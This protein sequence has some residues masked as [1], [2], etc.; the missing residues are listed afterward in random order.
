MTTIQ[1]GYRGDYLYTH[2]TLELLSGDVS[3]SKDAP[4][5]G[6][7]LPGFDL[8]TTDGK[9]VRTDDFVGKRP[10]LLITGSFTC[11]MTASSN[12]KLQQ[13]H[14]RFG[15][16]IAFVM[17]H[18]REA[19]PGERYDQPHSFKERGS[20]KLWRVWREGNAPTSR[21]VA[22]ALYRW[23]RVSASCET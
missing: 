18:V 1:A 21:K 13:L 20:P 3:F 6:D 16:R 7:P 2:V 4:R 14:Q 19:H 11:P 23:P 9:R 15:S 12:P 22:V 10:L 17:L 8:P 5:P